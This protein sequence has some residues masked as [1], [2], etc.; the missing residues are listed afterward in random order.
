[1]CAKD[2]HGSKTL[3]LLFELHTYGRSI[4]TFEGFDFENERF[5]SFNLLVYAYIPFFP[6]QEKEERERE[7]AIL[8]GVKL[9][10]ITN[11]VTSILTK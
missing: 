7:R 5:L 3:Q 9:Y 10:S 11:M 2:V 6:V 4:E 8:L 1:L